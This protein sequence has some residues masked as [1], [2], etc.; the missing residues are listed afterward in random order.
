MRGRLGWRSLSFPASRQAAE[1]APPVTDALGGYTAAMVDGN[2]PL[3]YL[4]C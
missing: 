3:I 1:A 2:E 4:N